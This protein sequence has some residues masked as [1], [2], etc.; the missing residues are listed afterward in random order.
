M[1]RHNCDAVILVSVLNA[2]SAFHPVGFMSLYEYTRLE[3]RWGLWFH[4]I[5][6]LS[7]LFVNLSHQRCFYLFADWQYNM[8]DVLLSVCL[9]E[10]INSSCLCHADVNIIL[11]LSTG[12]LF[13]GCPFL[14]HSSEWVQ[15]QQHSWRKQRRKRK[16]KGRGWDWLTTTSRY[17]VTRPLF[18]QSIIVPLW[19]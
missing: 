7:V 16:R 9:C 12:M 11:S 13:S 2:S 4:W 10:G 6:I 8:S 14:L 3:R 17:S 5:S 1:R 15:Q 19:E 18:C